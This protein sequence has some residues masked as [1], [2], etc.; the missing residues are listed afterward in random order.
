M[1]YF[2]QDDFPLIFGQPFKAPHGRAFLRAF[3]IPAFEPFNR[4]EFANDPAQETAAI[5]EGTI[6]K[7]SQAIMQRLFG[8]TRLLHE[9]DERLLQDV[10]GL[11]VAQAQGA[12]VEEYLRGA[13][14]I[15]AFAPVF[16]LVCHKL[17][18]IDTA[19]LIFV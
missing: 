10:L 17:Y 1:P 15:Q 19:T 18:P 11:A 12:P 14:L 3:V 13:L 9:R 7:A 16:R 4:F 8:L 5:V 2:Q 6:A